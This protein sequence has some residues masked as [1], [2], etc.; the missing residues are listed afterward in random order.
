MPTTPVREALYSGLVTAATSST[1]SDSAAPFV[2]NE[3]QGCYVV[4]QSASG[5]Y[6][7]QQALISSNTANQITISGSWGTTPSAN[8]YYYIIEIPDVDSAGDIFTAPMV[9]KGTATSGG[10]NTLTDTTKW[11]PNNKLA[12]LLVYIYAGTGQGQ[13]N[14]VLSNNANQITMTASWNTQPDNTS[15]YI[16]IPVIVFNPPSVVSD[17]ATLNQA[18]IITAPWLYNGASFDRQ[19]NNVQTRQTGSANLQLQFIL[20]MYNTKELAILVASS[21]GNFASQNMTVEVSPDSTNW[22][23]IDSSLSLGTGTSFAKQYDNTHLGATLAVNPAAFPYVRITIPAL[24][25][26]ISAIATCS[27]KQ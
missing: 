17:G 4:V 9:I 26:G 12:G 18:A 22:T 14:Q 3:Y 19:R 6:N 15:Q 7:P 8:D 13:I 23:T 5:A 10:S 27:S 16:I 2:A 11:F 24:G 21:G 25:T 20:N 1:I